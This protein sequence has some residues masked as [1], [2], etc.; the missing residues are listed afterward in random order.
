[1]SFVSIPAL[2]NAGLQLRVT[3]LWT[4]PFVASEHVSVRPN[5]KFIE[6]DLQ[7]DGTVQISTHTAA[8]FAG[9]QFILWW[10]RD[11]AHSGA[12]QG[13]AFFLDPPYTRPTGSNV[14]AVYSW[15]DLKGVDL[16]GMKVPP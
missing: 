12:I 11:A 3:N 8:D 10:D 16:S 15:N 1:M 9:S 13:L 4:G 7:V 6:A 5:V 14:K 2:A